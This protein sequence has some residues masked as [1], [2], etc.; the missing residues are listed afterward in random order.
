MNLLRC[1]GLCNRPILEKITYENETKPQ[2]KH[3]K[4]SENDFEE[5]KSHQ[6][7]NDRSPNDQRSDVLNPN[8]PEFQ[9][10]L[11]NMTNQLNPQHPTYRSSRGRK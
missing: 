3:E 1:L 6:W 4:F 7:D 11:D 5:D 8:N 2:I 10:A 9:A